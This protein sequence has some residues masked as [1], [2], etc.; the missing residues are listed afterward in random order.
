MS[1][2]LKYTLDQSVM[3]TGVQPPIKASVIDPGSTMTSILI[4]S[5]DYDDGRPNIITVNNDEIMCMD[6]FTSKLRDEKIDII[7]EQQNL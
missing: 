3:Y 1:L 7:N 2:N 4:F 6:D 5:N